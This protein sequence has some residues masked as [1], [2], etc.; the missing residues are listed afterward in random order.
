MKQ[1]KKNPRKARK[2]SRPQVKSHGRISEVASA[3]KP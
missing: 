1:N 2:Y 3:F